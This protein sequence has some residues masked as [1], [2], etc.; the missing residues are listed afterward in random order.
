MAS[1]PPKA[2]PFQI[3]LLGIGQILVWGGS[4]FILA[5]L[6][7]PVV[8]ETGWSRQWVYGG[9]SLGV[10]VSGLLAP[11]CGRLIAR[12]GG[13]TLLSLSGLGVAAG[14][15]LMASAQ[16]LPLFLLAWVIMGIGMAAG[17]YDA[18][19]A[20]LG[21]CY[22][23]QARSAITGITLVSGFCTAITWPIAALLVNHLGWR[24]ACL[25]Y[26]AVL[27]LTIWP[28]YRH[29]LPAPALA[30]Q[31]PRPVQPAPTVPVNRTLYGVLCALFTL[32]AVLMTAISIQLI[33]LL[34]SLGYGLATAV[35][36][37]ACLGPS[38][39]GSRLIDLVNRNGHP[40]WTA[41]ASVVCTAAG[42]LLVT[43]GPS[44]VWVTVVGLV[45]FGAGNGLRAIIR[46]TL[47]LAL[48]S[49]T[50]YAAILGRM[51]RP[52]LLGQAATPLLCG[53][54]LEHQGPQA[55]LGL[56]CL[57]ALVNVALVA[58]LFRALFG[59]GAARS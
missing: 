7:D 4:F 25:A 16:H 12:Q 20:T 48:W 40:L 8:Q 11:A 18:L 27:L 14:L 46:G 57:L 51:A 6:A 24:G 54:V 10:L 17:L 2:S 49:P 45:V 21:T 5:V 55:V 29:A 19:F 33:T 41:L 59:G 44:V 22:G 34:Q 39:V 23:T 32:G 37:S 42:L 38:Q 52:A 36:L 30:T 35:A 9:L 43:L 31:T 13:R 58:W 3:L 15:T 28:L 1:A 56:L 47:P 26:A 53:Y 50:E